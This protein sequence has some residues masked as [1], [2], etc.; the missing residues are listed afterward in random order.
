MTNAVTGAKFRSEIPAVLH[1]SSH[2]SLTGS[3]VGLSS[4]K[5][6]K[7]PAG[8]CPSISDLSAELDV[9]DPIAMAW[10]RRNLRCARKLD[11]GPFDDPNVS[12]P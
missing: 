11:G 2:Q 6:Q 3:F 9:G 1:H 10:R 7:P 12:V 5:R 8:G 4:P